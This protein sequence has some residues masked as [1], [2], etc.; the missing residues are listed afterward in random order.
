MRVRSTSLLSLILPQLTSDFLQRSTFLFSYLFFGVGAEYYCTRKGMSFLLKRNASEPRCLTVGIGQDKS[1]EEQMLQKQE[2]SGGEVSRS[3]GHR[4]A[5]ERVK[6]NL[7]VFTT[8]PGS[9]ISEQPHRMPHPGG[10]SGVHCGLG[11]RVVVLRAGAG[12]AWQV[13]KHVAT[14][15]DSWAHQSSGT[16]LASPFLS[17]S[18]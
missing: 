6:A 2:T 14:G 1:T 5:D 12:S 17:S 16:R 18:P 7:T 13:T 10:N 3:E 9:R 15:K 11:Q 8:W 4:E